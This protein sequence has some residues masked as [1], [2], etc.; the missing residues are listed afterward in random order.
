ML[1]CIP[2]RFQERT[3]RPP[4]CA[5]KD[6]NTHTRSNEVRQEMNNNRLRLTLDLD[7]ID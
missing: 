7:Q 3:P 4:T 5:V 2:N 1:Y 6:E